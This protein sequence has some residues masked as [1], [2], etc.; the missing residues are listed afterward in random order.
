MLRVD[1]HIVRTARGWLLQD[2]D[3]TTLCRFRDLEA[4]LEDSEARARQMQ[5]RGLNVRLTIHVSGKK[6]AVQDFP[7][8]TE[9]VDS[10]AFA[11][12]GLP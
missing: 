3:A 4:A 6:A 11:R 7:A 5:R 10:Y 1:L 2:A 9:K 12:C 8:P